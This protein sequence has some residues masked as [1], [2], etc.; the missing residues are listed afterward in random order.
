MRGAIEG[1]KHVPVGGKKMLRPDIVLIDDP[2]TR[3]SARSLVQSARRAE[4]INA[5]IKG[6]GGPKKGV[7][8]LAA[9]TIMQPG[10]LTSRLL[11][12]KLTPGW[13]GKVYHAVRKFPDD[14]LLWDQY[15]EIR[16]DRGEKEA[17]AFYVKNRN[18]M[19]A[20]S[21]VYWP[22]RFHAEKFEISGIQHLMNLLS[23]GKGRSV[24]FS[25]C[26]AGGGRIS[27]S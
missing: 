14:L 19:D 24:G 8:V 22:E 1:Q 4:F 10:D 23:T 2:Q 26:G 16:V 17:T 18:A 6:L 5:G 21:E 12:R 15:N 27:L 7:S 20:G 13:R 9:A 25:S 3:D 11:D